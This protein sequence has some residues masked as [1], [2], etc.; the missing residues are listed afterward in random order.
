MVDKGTISTVSGKTATVIPAF[1]DAPVSIEL[2]VPFY[3]VDSLSVGMPVVYA[4]FQDNTGV[5]LAR[6]DGEWNHNL[7]GNVTIQGNHTVEGSQTVDGNQ[8]IEGAATITGN[9]TAADLITGTARFNTHTHSCPDGGTS[10]P[11]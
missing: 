4:Q 2:V 8:T 5:I 6:M 10:G 9:V 3:L 11:R 7:E 1:S